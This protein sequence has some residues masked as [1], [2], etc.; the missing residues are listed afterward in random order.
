MRDLMPAVTL[1][2][3]VEVTDETT[4]SRVANRRVYTKRTHFAS[5]YKGASD[6]PDVV[7]KLLTEE[8][9]FVLRHFRKETSD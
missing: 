6:V 4:H 8:T 9:A 1:T 2:I 3:V 7:A 5:K